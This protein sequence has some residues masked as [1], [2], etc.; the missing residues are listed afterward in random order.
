[1]M[2][3]KTGKVDIVVKPNPS[4]LP[5]FSQDADFEVTSVMGNRVFFNGFNTLLPPTDYVR[6]RQALSMAVDVKGIVDN[7]LEG[8]GAMPKS[9][10][11]PRFLVFPT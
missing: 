7:I 1:M 2:A 5:A 10:L 4:D 3:L 6:V 9:Y 8:A 11:A